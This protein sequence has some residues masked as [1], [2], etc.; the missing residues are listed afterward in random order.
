MESIIEKTA[1]I[2]LAIIATIV[3]IIC[4][5]MFVMQVVSHGYEHKYKKVSNITVPE[6]T[7]YDPKYK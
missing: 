5:G 6:N 3:V 1:A 2:T 7:L 4:I